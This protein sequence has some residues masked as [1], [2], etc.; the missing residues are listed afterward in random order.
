M[1][2]IVFELNLVHSLTA[3]SVN[4][5]FQNE[6]LVLI[7]TRKSQYHSKFSLKITKIPQKYHYYPF[8]K[9]LVFTIQSHMSWGERT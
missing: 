1:F 4:H 7:H 2:A 8:M 6:R 3:L 9:T 5:P